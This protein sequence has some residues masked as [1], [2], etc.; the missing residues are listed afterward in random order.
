LFNRKLQI[1]QEGI[2]SKSSGESVNGST[3][4]QLA[5]LTTLAAK[6]TKNDSGKC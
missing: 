3:P 1:F 2:A 6:P 4:L 5:K